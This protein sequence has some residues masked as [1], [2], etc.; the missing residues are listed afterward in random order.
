MWK[1]EKA[2]LPGPKGWKGVVVESRAIIDVPSDL[3]L[4][5]TT[6]GGGSDAILVVVYLMDFNY[7]S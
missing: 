5:T 7:F 1:M 2:A 6:R 4:V 3:W